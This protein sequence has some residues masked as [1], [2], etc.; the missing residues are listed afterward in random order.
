MWNEKWTIGTSIDSSAFQEGSWHG[1]GTSMVLHLP[2]LFRIHAGGLCTSPNCNQGLSFNPNATELT[3]VPQTLL[4]QHPPPFF[5]N[6]SGSS[7]STNDRKKWYSNEFSKCHQRMLRGLHYSKPKD[8]IA[9]RICWKDTWWGSNDVYRWWEAAI[10]I[11]LQGLWDIDTARSCT[12]CYFWA[13]N[14][15]EIH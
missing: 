12:S 7:P 2:A 1:L 13:S 8:D 14:L 11:F 6:E 4:R 5:Q 15:L 10:Q 3:R 9:R